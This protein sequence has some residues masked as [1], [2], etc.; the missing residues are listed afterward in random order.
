MAQI[1]NTYSE[2]MTEIV[3]I[4]QSHTSVSTAD[5]GVLDNANWGEVN[6]PLVFFVCTSAEI[7]PNEIAYNMLMIVGDLINEDLLQQTAKQSAMFEITKDM[8][9][10]FLNG[11]VNNEY[12]I[13]PDSIISEPFVDRFPDLVTGWQTTFKIT[14]PYDNSGCDLPFE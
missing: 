3:T 7:L 8:I 9:A 2:L 10:Y 12:N 1:I 4:T 6:Y 11:N 14:L 5:S 13:N